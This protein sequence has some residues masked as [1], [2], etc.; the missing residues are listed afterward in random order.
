CSGRPSILQPAID[1]RLQPVKHRR[2]APRSSGIDTIF[3]D[4]SVPS[5]VEMSARSS[6]LFVALL[7]S[8]SLPLS[9]QERRSIDLTIRD[10]GISI[11]DSRR[12]IGVRLNFRDRVMEEVIGVNAT[13]WEPYEET[14]RVR[15][16]AIG[17]PL[18]VSR[19]IVGGGAGIL[20]V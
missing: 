2:A 18:T 16:L 6:I 12:T 10:H 9:A 7:L 19:H 4:S 3:R 14:G 11:G 15:G 5:P 1:G 17:L 13:V 8:L 20:G